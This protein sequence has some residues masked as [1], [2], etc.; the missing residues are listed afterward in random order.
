MIEKMSFIPWRVVAL[1][2][3]LWML[4]SL[5]CNFFYKNSNCL[6]DLISKRLHYRTNES[7]IT[8][9]YLHEKSEYGRK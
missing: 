9:I 3:F 8:V 6:T 1:L 7:I 4:A 5:L 2:F